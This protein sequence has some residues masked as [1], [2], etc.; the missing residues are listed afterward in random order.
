MQIEYICSTDRFLAEADRWNELVGNGVTNHTYLTH[1]WFRAWWEAFG[2]NKQLF[3]IVVSQ[4][5]RWMAVAPLC[6]T[7]QK[8]GPISAR[9]L[10][11]LYSPVGPRC[12]FI[13]REDR[14]HLVAALLDAI[15]EQSDLWTVCCLDRISEDSPTSRWLPELVRERKIP[16]DTT[17]F[18]AS[19][20]VVTQGKWETYVKNLSRN[21]R[22]AI[23]RA[24]RDVAKLGSTVEYMCMVDHDEIMAY[25][26]KL[27]DV[28]ARSWKKD[29][30]ADMGADEAARRFYWQLSDSLSRRGKLAVWAVEVDGLA[31]AM[32]YCLRDGGRIVGM[33]SDFDDAHKDAAPGNA[34][35]GHMLKDCFDQGMTEY[36]FSGLAYGYKL[37]LA[38]GTRRQFT[39]EM[40]ATRLWPSLLHRARTLKRSLWPRRK[41]DPASRTRT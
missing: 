3:I 6:I 15:L 26:P 39:V 29:L 8:A 25:L 7:R 12:E 2:N 30:G 31:I 32:L 24:W 11:F 14:S 18:Q 33:R 13:L 34:L 16:C 36:D 38:S 40:Y 17:E 41:Q 23:R 1:E 27:F 28:S 19:P 5:D 37:A 10:E 4:D 21:R 35:I 22:R 9:S 20:Y